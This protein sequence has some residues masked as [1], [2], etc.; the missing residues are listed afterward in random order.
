MRRD[1]GVNKR[2]C[3]KSFEE[4]VVEWTREEV[5]G[6]VRIEGRESDRT[7]SLA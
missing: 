4:L 7:V 3:G 1:G 5:F 2:K 6:S